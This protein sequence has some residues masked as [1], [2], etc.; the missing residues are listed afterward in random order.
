MKK[1]FLT[2]AFLITF[3]SANSQ[4]VLNSYRFEAAAVPA[5]E[6]MYVFN[7]PVDNVSNHYDGLQFEIVDEKTLT[8]RKDNTLFRTIYPGTRD[9]TQYQFYLKNTGDATLTHSFT[10][11]TNEPVFDSSYSAGNVLAGDSVAINMD[12]YSYLL[13]KGRV[14]ADFNSINGD[15]DEGFYNFKISVQRDM[16]EYYDFDGS[17]T[18]EFFGDYDLD[19]LG[20]QMSFLALAKM[21]STNTDRCLLGGSS[22]TRFY[23]KFEADDEITAQ[24]YDGTNFT[25]ISSVTNS[26]GTTI[27]DYGWHQYGLSYDGT[28]IKLYQDGIEIAS[29]VDGDATGTGTTTFRIGTRGSSATTMNGQVAQVMIWDRPLT[30]TEFASLNDDIDDVQDGLVVQYA[31]D[32][33]LDGTTDWGDDLSTDWASA[34]GGTSQPF[35][36]RTFD[37]A[38]AYELQETTLPF[39]ESVNPTDIKVSPN[40]DKVYVTCDNTDKIF[41]FSLSTPGDLTTATLD[42]SYTTTATGIVNQG[43]TWNYTGKRFYIA[44][45]GTTDAIREFTTSVAYDLTSTVT[46]S[47]IWT[48]SPTVPNSPLQITWSYDHK[49]CWV[50]SLSTDSVHEFTASTPGSTSSLTFVGAYLG[51]SGDTIH[52]FWISDDGRYAIL[53]ESNINGLEMYY[54]PTENALAGAVHI[55]SVDLTNL[56]NSNGWTIT[57]TGKIYI[58]DRTNDTFFKYAMVDFM[59][60]TSYVSI[61]EVNAWNEWVDER[62]ITNVTDTGIDYGLSAKATSQIPTTYSNIS[63]SVDSLM[64]AIDYS[65][66]VQAKVDANQLQDIHLPSS[67]GWSANTNHNVDNTTWTQHTA[68]GERDTNYGPANVVVRADQTPATNGDDIWW[69]RMMIRQDDLDISPIANA[70]SFYDEYNQLGQTAAAPVYQ[71]FFATMSVSDDSA[72]GDYSIE[73]TTFVGITNHMEAL[74]PMVSG[75]VYRWGMWAKRG[76]TGT[77]QEISGWTNVTVSP[78]IAITS[79]DWKYYSGQVTASSTANSALKIWINDT[80]GTVGESVLIDGF[81]IVAED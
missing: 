58:N 43:I 26:T 28:T 54:L 62:G 47:T 20:D 49:K 41:Q 13:D 76:A 19:A 55:S 21:D 32:K 53:E 50:T 71:A 4:F 6:A 57:P 81:R 17:L 15:A 37:V 39:G 11:T 16:Q 70:A 27:T 48:T 31:G 18:A 60:Q 59:P 2:L 33:D 23:I 10:S 67:V 75:T 56:D 74:V 66:I 72:H 34:G 36:I 25:N 73:A 45:S 80:T 68:S 52:D 12:I 29:K 9:L 78:N 40:E 46:I 61:N 63:I 51:T 3:I 1:L 42:G 14:T 22:S 5:P 30:A 8:Q 77:G 65:I 44:D 64:P 79:T 24:I 38:T 35:L 7:N 69:D